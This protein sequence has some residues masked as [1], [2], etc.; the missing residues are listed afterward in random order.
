VV[1]HVTAVSVIPGFYKL[2]E[3]PVNGYLLT[4]I[5][6]DGADSDGL[7]GLKLGSGE[8]VTCQ[9]VNDD[10]GVDLEILFQQDFRT[11]HHRLLVVRL[12]TIQVQLV[13]GWHGR[14][15]ILRLGQVC[16]LHFRQQF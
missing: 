1:Q 13:R 5:K 2:S 3:S 15:P 16:L 6:C 10:Q 7:D 12:T 14:S 9:F 4:G 11:S 8:N